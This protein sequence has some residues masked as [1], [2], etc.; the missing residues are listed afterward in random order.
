MTIVGSRSI[1]ASIVV[2]LAAVAG[3]A[4]LGVA[5]VAKPNTPEQ[6]GITPNKSAPGQARRVEPDSHPVDRSNRDVHVDAPRTSV[7]VGKDTG[8]VRVKAP[9]ADVK[10]DPRQGRVRVR[11]PHVDLNIRW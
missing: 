10:V 4:S 11:A 1:L 9:Y 7:D 3:V 5:Q 2:G 8:K 6:G